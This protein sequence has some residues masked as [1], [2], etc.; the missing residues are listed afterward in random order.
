VLYDA[1]KRDQDLGLATNQASCHDE[2]GMC[3]KVWPCYCCL[4]LACLHTHKVPPSVER[5]VSQH[6]RV[7]VSVI[8]A[9]ATLASG[10]SC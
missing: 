2:T 4:K 7:D 9:Y 3:C 10:A 8:A 6:G 5:K 1:G